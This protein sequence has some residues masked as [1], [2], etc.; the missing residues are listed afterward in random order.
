MRMPV[1]ATINSDIPYLF[2]ELGYP[3]KPERDAVAIA[4]RLRH[5][6]ENRDALVGDGMALRERIR[7]G[8]A[9]PECAARP[10]SLYD[11]VVRH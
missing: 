7:D 3:L 6:A 4:D 10:G 8:F 11:A 5:Y 1:I 9:A 2:G